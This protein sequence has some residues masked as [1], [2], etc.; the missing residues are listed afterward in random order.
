MGNSY[1]N[2]FTYNKHA[3]MVLIDCSFV[4]T[5]TNAAGVTFVNKS[6]VSTTSLS[7]GINNVFM[8]TSTTPATGNPNPAAGEIMIQF[9]DS[10]QTLY[11]VN[12]SFVSPLAGSPSTSTTANVINVITT[13]GSATAA[14]WITAGLPA[15]ITPAVGV[16]FVAAASAVI[17]GSAQVDLRATAG[18]GIDHIEVV[19]SNMNGNLTNGVVRNPA[20]ATAA[21]GYLYLACFKNT[22]LTAP[23][24]GSIIKMEF[25]LGD[26]SA[27]L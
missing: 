6:G 9:M 2:Q 16:S 8:H 10:Y 18:A 7:P 24:T 20:L 17:G 23:A 1:L 27:R 11:G 13:L 19:G 15:G 12:S 14:Q 22:A 4:V 3:K 21:G 26:S 25:L 5:P